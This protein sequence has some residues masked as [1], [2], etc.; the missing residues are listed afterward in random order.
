[1]GAADVVECTLTT[2]QAAPCPGCGRKVT[3]TW[4]ASG[5]ADKCACG[6]EAVLVIVTDKLLRWYWRDPLT[7]PEGSGTRPSPERPAVTRAPARTP[8]QLRLWE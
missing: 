4:Q 1:M 8:D 7:L 6:M 3:L 2:G 5:E